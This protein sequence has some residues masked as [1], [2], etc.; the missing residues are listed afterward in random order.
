MKKRVC[1]ITRIIPTKN[2]S[3]Q[4]QKNCNKSIKMEE[5]KVKTLNVCL[6]GKKTIL[7]KLTKI[8]EL[9]NLYVIYWSSI[10]SKLKHSQWQVW[11]ILSG[12]AIA[13]LHNYITIKNQNYYLIIELV[14]FCWS[15]SGLILLHS[16]ACL[17]S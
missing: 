13:I 9:H 14:I 6:L 12:T 3:R 5:S 10:N 7:I 11:L 2:K 17:L 15:A 16:E 1:K 4:Q 8:N